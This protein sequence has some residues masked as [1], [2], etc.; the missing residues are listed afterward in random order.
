MLSGQ[1]VTT[2]EVE[3]IPCT[4]EE[5]L[6]WTRVAP[7][8]NTSDQGILEYTVEASMETVTLTNVAIYCEHTRIQTVELA[9]A[10]INDGA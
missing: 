3:I 9:T 5:A 10:I 6:A 2:P 1:I 4:N 7:S 8:G